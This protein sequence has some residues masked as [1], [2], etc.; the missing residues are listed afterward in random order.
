MNSYKVLF[1]RDKIRT[2]EYSIFQEIF[3]K[4]YKNIGAQEDM[5]LFCNEIKDDLLS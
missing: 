5:G 4:F 1:N 2:G 3:F